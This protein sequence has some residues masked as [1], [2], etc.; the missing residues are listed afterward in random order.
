MSIANN[1]GRYGQTIQQ[2]HG[3]RGENQLRGTYGRYHFA[4]YQPKDIACF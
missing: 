1:Q 4:F 2:G 3:S